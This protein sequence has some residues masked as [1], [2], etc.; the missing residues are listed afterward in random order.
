MQRSLCFVGT[1]NN[2]E[3][4]IGRLA[5]PLAW[6]LELLAKPPGTALTSSTGPARSSSSSRHLA[7][8]AAQRRGVPFAVVRAGAAALAFVIGRIDSQ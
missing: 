2:L 8:H 4:P 1:R 6:D 7:Q 5:G 3:D